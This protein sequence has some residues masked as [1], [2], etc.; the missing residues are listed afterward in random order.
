M[1]KILTLPSTSIYF[2][3]TEGAHRTHISVFNV[4]KFRYASV[5]LIISLLYINIFSLPDFK[6]TI[7]CRFVFMISNPGVHRIWTTVLIVFL[8]SGMY[9]F[10]P[11][12][13]SV[14]YLYFSVYLFLISS[15]TSVFHFNHTRISIDVSPSTSFMSL[16]FGLFFVVILFSICLTYLKFF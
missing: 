3:W 12:L 14:F 7:N 11:T 8:R 5:I 4:P 13:L 2:L 10:R 1:L 16:R 6:R 15:I 9:I